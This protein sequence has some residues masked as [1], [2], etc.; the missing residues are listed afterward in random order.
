MGARPGGALRPGTPIHANLSNF[1]CRGLVSLKPRQM[2]LID[3]TEPFLA[4]PC[5]IKRWAVR[6]DL[7]YVLSFAPEDRVNRFSVVTETKE[8]RGLRTC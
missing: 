5:L 7:R 3:L 2:F 4:K 8:N 1:L 6:R